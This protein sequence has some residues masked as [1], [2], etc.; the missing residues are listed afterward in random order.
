MSL[1]KDVA[2]NGVN[3]LSTM[4]D[5]TWNMKMGQKGAFGKKA[6]LHFWEFWLDLSN[7]SAVRHT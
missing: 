1:K 7:S 2:A 4:E 6:S 5:R 3:S